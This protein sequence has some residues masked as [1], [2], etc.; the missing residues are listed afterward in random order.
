MGFL[1]KY[2]I[3]NELVPLLM[4]VLIFIKC[5]PY[6]VWE[7]SEILSL[8]I[9]VIFAVMTFFYI[10]L[11]N[12]KRKVAFCILF[13]AYFLLSIFRNAHLGTLLNISL[14]FIPFIR[15]EYLSKIY[16]LFKTILSVCYLISIISLI[17]ILLGLQQPLGMI[18]PLNELKTYGYLEYIMLIFPTNVEDLI[19]RFC[20]VFDEPGVVGTMCGLMIIAEKFKFSDWR[21]LIILIAGFLSFSLYFYLILSIFLFFKSSTKY[22]ILLIIIVLLLFA[23]TSD[24]EIFYN[25]IWGR[26]EFEDGKMLG[27]NRN[28]DNFKQAWDYYKYTPQIIRGYGFKMAEEYSESASIQLFIFRDGLLFVVL[29][30]ISYLFYIKS[31]ISSKIMSLFIFAVIFLTLYQR[32]GFCEVDFIFLFSVI[33]IK[34]SNYVGKRNSCFI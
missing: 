10:D 16:D 26:L 12:S 19:P 30:F 28:S 3:K 11:K 24:N 21:V 1:K 14:V 23:I 7:I 25:R 29:Y 15:Y 31:Y 18:E 17:T 5:R 32:P 6:F 22:R 20:A 33:I 2:S 4:A 8:S 13:T 9:S 27:N 34:Y